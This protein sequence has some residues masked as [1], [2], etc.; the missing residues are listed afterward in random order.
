MPR[1][2]IVMPCRD[3]GAYLPEA[4]ASLEAQSFDDYEVVAIDDGSA[5]DTRALLDAWAGRDRRVRILE[6]PPLG[7]TAALQ[8][9]ADAA[10]GDVLVRMDADDIAHPARL[11][12]QVQLLDERPD[13]DACGTLVRYFPRHDLRDGALRYERWINS[14]V[15]HDDIVRDIFVECPI[16]HPSLALRRTALD[17]AGGYQDRG[18]PEDYDLVLRLWQNGVRF[19]KVPE[20][21]LRWRER[22]DRSSRID[23]RYRP[24]A[25]RRCKVHY[26]R[27]TLLRHADGAVVWGAGPV[28]KT[29][30]RELQRQNVRVRAFVDLDPRKIGQI[31]HGA[32]VI[33]PHAVRGCAGALMLAAVGQ[34][35]GRTQ[36]R[37][38]L[39]AQ[40]FLEGRD[41]VAV[42]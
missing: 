26:M 32:P 30:A 2:S 16:A 40:G 23:D 22:D 13:V 8:R 37:N 3:A 20:T 11:E 31:V 27:H 1:A 39:R 19:A 12:R 41:F 24:D 14:L 21:L 10:Q 33:A 7:I 36:I 6:Q 5:D 25:F 29:F 9:A 34:P 42:A 38:A 4:I 18:W 17:R 35:D 28:G 15:E